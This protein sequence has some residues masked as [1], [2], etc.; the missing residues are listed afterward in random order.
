MDS[1]ENYFS[2]ITTGKMGLWD[3][4]NMKAKFKNTH[5]LA[6]TAV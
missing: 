1:A 4:C 3:W 5:I 6:D 2:N